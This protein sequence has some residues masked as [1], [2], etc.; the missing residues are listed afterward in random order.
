[1]DTE[2]IHSSRPAFAILVSLIAALLILITGERARNLREF[3]T[4]LAS[5]VKFSIV[6]SMVP[7][8]L[9]GKVIEYTF[10]SISPGLSIQFRVDALGII[11]GL[12]ASFLWIITSFYSIGYVRSLNEHAQTRYFMCF[13]I[14]LFATIGV[15]FSANMF[16]TFLFYEIITICTFPLVAHKE[17]PEAIQG[18][19]KYLAYLLGT[20]I[21]F[22][23]LAV[24]MTY[25]VAGTLD[26]KYE[27][28]LSGARG[29]GVSDTL[30]M[31]MFI[32][33]MAGI[34]K[35]AMMPLHGWLPAA[36]VAPTPV[37]ALLHA[38]A[39]V[40]TGVFVVVKVV[41]HIFGI[42]LLTQ[43]GL[44]TALAYFA[45]FTI[46]VAS[47][48]ALTQDNLKRRL[49][50]ST[51]SQLSY[52]ILGVAL[53]TPSGITG[54][55]M[56]ITLHAFGKITLFFTSGAIYVATHKTKVSELDGIG[57]QMPFTMFAF[58]LGALSMIGVPP[59]A[60]FISKWYLALGAI[61]AKQLPIIIILAASTLLN[62]GYFLPIIYAAFFKEPALDHRHNPGPKTKIQ[63][64]PVLMVV[65][66][67]LTGI[68]TLVLFLAPS[69][70]LDITRIA[71]HAVIGGN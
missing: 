37:S 8:I 49:A 15:A 2:I 50:Y 13:A 56:H 70:F 6:F 36:M 66:L 63:E 21:A 10:F 64:A 26:F 71:L 61:E 25:H 7:Y 39:V 53:L 24:F 12:T 57:R 47:V 43:L 40:K 27:G 69:F 23:L 30:L 14:A 20:S 5:L 44:G 9:D 54:S 4:I 22:Q 33:Y 52:V 32:L 68:G 41:L 38:V 65:P 16:T 59:L 60:G 46:I 3:W 29:K 31:I 19:R 55:I 67:V 42:N 18:A 45:S 62:A 51:I 11:F 28:L 1:V 48:I 58:T 17:T 34:A 35:A